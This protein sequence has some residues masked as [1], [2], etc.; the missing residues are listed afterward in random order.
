MELSFATQFAEPTRALQA[1]THRSHAH[2]CANNG[3]LAADNERLEFLG[4]AVLDLAVSQRLMEHHPQLSEGELSKRRAAVVNEGVLAQI[5]RE[6][7]LSALIYLGRGEDLTGGR[8]KPSVLADAFEAVVAVVYLEH[9]MSGAL[10]IVDRLFGA[11]LAEAAAGTLGTDHKTLVQEW[12]QGRH[13]GTPRY[14]VVQQTGPDHARL[15]EV[16]LIVQGDAVGVG[17]GM[18]KKEAEQAAAKAALTLLAER[19]AKLDPV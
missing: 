9:G 3:D 6:A 1:L 18:S 4:D 11:V 7:G 19:A 8:D 15:F 13:L 2:E 5:A 12:V 14:R 16:E 10:G 17:R